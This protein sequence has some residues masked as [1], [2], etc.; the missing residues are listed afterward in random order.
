MAA[1][2]S[3]QVAADVIRYLDDFK[4]FDSE[5]KALIEG[6][7]PFLYKNRSATTQVIVH[8]AD[9]FG[10]DPALWT[11]RKLEEVFVRKC[12]STKYFPGAGYQGLDRMET[13]SWIVVY[14]N[15]QM[16]IVRLFASKF[17]VEK[18]EQA[19]KALQFYEAWDTDFPAHP[20]FVSEEEEPAFSEAR[21]F[22]SVIELY[23]N[24][25]GEKEALKLVSR[26]KNKLP[27]K[28]ILTYFEKTFGIES[29][30]KASEAL[31]SSCIL[32]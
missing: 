1:I 4:T 16:K 14:P 30:P 15:E 25:F 19:M 12:S 21:H 2:A 6:F 5:S 23:G 29:V 20:T 27:D 22:L 26:W 3:P 8:I 18:T 13:T 17:G 9:R 11:I 24:F 28:E 32:M 7:N 31:K 10:A